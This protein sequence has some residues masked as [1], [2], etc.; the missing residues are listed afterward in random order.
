MAVAGIINLVMPMDIRKEDI[1]RLARL[2]RID[3][4]GKEEELVK[5]ALN[6]LEY[7]E[8]LKDIRTDNIS[9]MSGAT[10]MVNCADS[11]DVDK[12]FLQKGVESFPES[13]EG[14]LRVPGV[15]KGDN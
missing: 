6:I 3:I 4:Q 12:T 13:K 14:Y 8:Q 1:E 15:M 5:D 9:P 7:F 2:A 11:D 10:D